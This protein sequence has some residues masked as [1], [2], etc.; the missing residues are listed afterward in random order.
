VLGLATHLQL[1]LERLL[2]LLLTVSLL[3]VFSS[4]LLMAKVR[5]LLQGRGAAQRKLL[6][7]KLLQVL[8]QLLL[9]P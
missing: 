4:L 8:L 1:L 3:T 6:L 2:W 9:V 5:L 7:A